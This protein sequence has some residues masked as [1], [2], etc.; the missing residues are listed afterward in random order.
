MPFYIAI[1]LFCETEFILYLF[2]FWGE[3]KLIPW[4]LL[5]QNQWNNEHMTSN[6]MKKNTQGVILC[7]ISIL[8]MKLTSKC[9]S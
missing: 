4:K 2:K 7:R 3:L 6:Q 8:C 1:A 9:D 5:K